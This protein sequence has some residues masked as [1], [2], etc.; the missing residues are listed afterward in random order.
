MLPPPPSDAKVQPQLPPPMPSTPSG[1]GPLL[2]ESRA[3]RTSASY[4]PE[5]A[6][7]IVGRWR[8]PEIKKVSCNSKT[9]K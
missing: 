6:S 4:Q 5:T 1:E 2:L 7:F 9:M 3:T 8:K